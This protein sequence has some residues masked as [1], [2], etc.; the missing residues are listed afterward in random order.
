MVVAQLM[1]HAHVDTTLNVYTQV[2][3]GSLRT[4]ANKVGVE[5]L[6]IVQSAPGG[7]VLEL[8]CLLQAGK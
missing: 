6:G 2:L 1:A 4:A 5:L 3:V 8:E 7:T